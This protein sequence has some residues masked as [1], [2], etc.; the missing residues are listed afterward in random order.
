MYP[1]RVST[2]RFLD[3]GVRGLR[4]IGSSRG[5]EFRRGL[6]YKPL[7]TSLTEICKGCA[8]LNYP[9]FVWHRWNPGTL[10]TVATPRPVIA[11]LVQPFSLAANPET[12]LKANMFRRS[13]RR[14][15]GSVCEVMYKPK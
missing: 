3:L 13:T 9:A 12:P 2:S 11:A 8:N 14:F 4:L 7:L 15:E 1:V 5:S 10:T 6:R